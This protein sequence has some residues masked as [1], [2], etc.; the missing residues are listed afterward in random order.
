MRGKRWK[1]T[2][3]EDTTCWSRPPWS[4]LTSLAGRVG[5]D[6]RLHQ[7]GTLS[8]ATAGP[9]PEVRHST[10]PRSLVSQVRRPSHRFCQNSHLASQLPSQPHA[11]VSGSQS[12]PSINH[13]SLL[14]PCHDDICSSG[15]IE[16]VCSGKICQIGR[17][18]A[19]CRARTW[20]RPSPWWASSWATPSWSSAAACGTATRA[21]RDLEPCCRMILM[22]AVNANFEEAQHKECL[23]RASFR[24][25]HNLAGLRAPVRWPLSLLPRTAFAAAPLLGWMRTGWRSGRE[26]A[27]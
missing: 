19:A 22:A 21:R 6:E 15:G 27:T 10:A 24:A 1:C 14:D 7:Q 18:H 17:R 9:G 13:F 5:V 4:A 25:A 2:E 16:C 8:C 23:L 3:S 20:T 11:Q 26:S 12:H